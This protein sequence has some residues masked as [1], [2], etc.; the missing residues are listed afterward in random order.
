MENIN[1]W[2][3][4]GYIGSIVIAVSLTMTSIVKLRWINFIGALVFTIYA[5]AIGVYPVALLNGYITLIDVYFLIKIYTSNHFFTIQKV[6]LG[7]E[8]L[9]QFL[10]FYKTDIAKYFPKFSIIENQNCF[11]FLA[12]RNMDVASVFVGRKMDENVMDILLDYAPPKYRDCKTGNYL[13]NKQNAIFTEIG[14]TKLYVKAVLKP[15]INYY[16][17]VGFEKKG[18]NFIKLL[19]DK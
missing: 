14:V 10:N 16:Q 7:D 15:Q 17:K 6:R 4:I 3:L 13:F 9:Q 18:D 5:I 1:I 11:V 8:Y 2:E 19:S 12:Y